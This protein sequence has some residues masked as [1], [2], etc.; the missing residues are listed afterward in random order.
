MFPHFAFLTEKIMIKIILLVAPVVLFALG[1]GSAAIIETK[2]AKA[3]AAPL[4]QVVVPKVNEN[5]AAISQ[6]SK[7]VNEDSHRIS[8]L[9]VCKS[10]DAEDVEA[11]HRAAKASAESLVH[12]EKSLDNYAAT[13][14]AANNSD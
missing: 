14:A 1:F 13:S 3:A 12:I 8:A 10:K 11:I 5:T 2:A 9:D 4:V 7:V 6:L